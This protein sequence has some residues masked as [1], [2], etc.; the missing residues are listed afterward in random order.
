[1]GLFRELYVAILVDH[2][3]DIFLQTAACILPVRSQLRGRAYGSRRPEAFVICP[4]EQVVDLAF[5]SDDAGHFSIDG[6]VLSPA[7]L[8]DLLDPIL[9]LALL[10]G[11]HLITASLRVIRLPPCLRGVIDAWLGGDVGVGGAVEMEIRVDLLYGVV[12]VVGT[13]VGIAVCHLTI[14]I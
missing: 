9:D 2:R 4:P 3:F 11:F 10:S 8:H 13:G 6:R 5:L 14:Y 1:M 12:G 7:Q